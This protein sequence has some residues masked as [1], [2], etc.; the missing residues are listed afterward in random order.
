[1]FYQLPDDAA[2]DPLGVLTRIG[3]RN[4]AEVSRVVRPYFVNRIILQSRCRA[5]PSCSG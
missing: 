4:V 1:M 5:T 3:E 2:I